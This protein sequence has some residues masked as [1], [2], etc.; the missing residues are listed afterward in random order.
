VHGIE[1]IVDRLVHLIEAV[2]GRLIHL[3]EAIAR[4]PVHLIEAK[5]HRGTKLVYLAAE[6]L[7][8]GLQ[9]AAKFPDVRF[10]HLKPGVDP[11]EFRID[12]IEAFIHPLLEAVD[13]LLGRLLL[14]RLHQH[15]ETYRLRQTG[16]LST[17]NRR[18]SP[19]APEPARAV[20]GGEEAV[21][22]RLHLAAA[23]VVEL[24]THGG[25]VSLEQL[26]PGAIAELRRSFGRA[27]DVGEEGR[28][29]RPP[30]GLV[31]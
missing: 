12:T 20:E 29:Q 26:A 22:H 19:G 13:P 14:H 23:V 2:V 28:R 10:D 18:H 17:A 27:D 5:D 4:F 24:A 1:A 3:V 16:Q 30:A 8:T 15:S 7:R 25:V 31:P 21:A 9:I 6:F 11:T